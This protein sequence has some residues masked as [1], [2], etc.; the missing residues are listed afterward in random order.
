MEGSG[1]SSSGLSDT[2]PISVSNSWSLR[3]L[4]RW[5]Y[6]LT[7]HGQL[8]Y[9]AVTGNYLTCTTGK[10]C[11]LLL[12]CC[13]CYHHHDDDDYY[14]TTTTPH[15]AGTA[16]APGAAGVCT[17]STISTSTGNTT[18]TTTIVLVLALY[19]QWRLFLLPL[20]A[21]LQHST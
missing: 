1:R 21:V 12:H 7:V 16:T 15:A 20:A 17:T 11:M 13:F 14:N 3:R 18:S 5:P 2:K 8:W 19:W 9:G 10:L 6:R 4:A